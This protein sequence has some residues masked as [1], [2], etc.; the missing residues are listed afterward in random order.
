MLNCRITVQDCQVEGC[1][2]GRSLV[3]RSPTECV[4][5]CVCVSVSQSVI[6]CNNYPIHPQ[7]VGRRVKTKK[8]IEEGWG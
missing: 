8:E 7:R 1:A 6:A 4:C 2:T 5:V 3:Q